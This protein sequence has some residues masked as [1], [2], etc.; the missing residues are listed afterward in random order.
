MVMASAS[1][2]SYVA[3]VCVCVCKCAHVRS[4]DPTLWHKS[5]QRDVEILC[6]GGSSSCISGK[7]L[8]GTCLLGFFASVVA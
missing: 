2:P 8:F 5:Y 4:E 3:N 6:W 7:N 1:E